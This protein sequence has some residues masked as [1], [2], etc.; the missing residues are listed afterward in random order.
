M[1]S[2]IVYAIRLNGDFANEPKSHRLYLVIAH[3]VAIFLVVIA[4]IARRIYL[5]SKN[6]RNPPPPNEAIGGNTVEAAATQG[7]L[8]KQNGISQPAIEAPKPELET[9]AAAQ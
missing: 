9:P 8:T 2:Y 5:K 1:V 3:L 4:L 6:A 7:G